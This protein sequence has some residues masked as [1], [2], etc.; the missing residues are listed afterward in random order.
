MVKTNIM[1]NTIKFKKNH[2]SGAIHILLN[3]TE[4]KPYTIGNLPPSFGF[5]YDEDKDKDGIYQWFNYKG[6]TYVPKKDSIWA[7]Q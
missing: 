2:D 7:I 5:K 4:Y 1:T 3:G 6:L